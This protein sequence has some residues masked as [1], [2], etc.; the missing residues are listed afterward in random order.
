MSRKR[1]ADGSPIL[2]AGQ[3]VEWLRNN[4]TW[5]PATVTHAVAIT[6]PDTTVRILAQIRTE[7]RGLQPQVRLV[8]ADTIRKIGAPA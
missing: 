3:L 1:T 2:G 6:G 4:G 7:S 8:R 5:V